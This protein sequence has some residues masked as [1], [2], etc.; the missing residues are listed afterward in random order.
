MKKVI[1]SVFAALIFILTMPVVNAIEKPEITDHEKVTIYLFRGEGCGHCQNAISY[2]LSLGDEYKDY[3]EV[4]AYE[5]WKNQNNSALAADVAKEVGT[6][7]T[8]GVPLIVVGEQYL[9]GFGQDSGEE[10]VKIALQYYEDEDYKDVVKEKLKEKDYDETQ[11]SLKEAAVSEGLTS[12]IQTPDSEST[13]KYDAIIIVGIFAVLIGGFAAL[14]V[15]G[16]K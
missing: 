1:I 11:E 16:K 15:I 9:G 4:K 7:Y 6:E 12:E 14:I 13:G 8:G 5:V 3:I 2:F 10:L